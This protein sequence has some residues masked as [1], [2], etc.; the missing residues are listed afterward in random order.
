M[1]PDFGVP[2]FGDIA[3]LVLFDLESGGLH[4]HSWGCVR[5][6]G[7]FGR[8]HCCLDVLFGGI[9]EPVWPGVILRFGL[10]HSVPPVQVFD[11]VSCW[12]CF[13]VASGSVGFAIVSEVGIVPV[14]RVTILSATIV[15]GVFI[16]MDR[17]CDSFGF[18]RA[19]VLPNCEFCLMK[20]VTHSCYS[21]RICLLRGL[22][23]GFVFLSLFGGC[24]LYD[25]NCSDWLELLKLECVCVT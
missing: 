24:G 3:V 10:V 25:I 11:M 14:V 19:M 2:H 12:G 21:S 22:S 15:V 6:G 5:S 23:R 8:T 16:V 13:S 1:P 7:W 17:H 18:I 4:G 20:L 9:L